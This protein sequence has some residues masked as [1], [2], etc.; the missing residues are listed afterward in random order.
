MRVLIDSAK[1]KDIQK[2]G[3]EA[4]EDVIATK[5]VNTKRFIIFASFSIFWQL[6]KYIR[7][8]QKVGVGGAV[9]DTDDSVV[10]G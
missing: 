1:V 7:Q 6:T 2:V 5:Y 8:W 9:A 4:Y 3:E 10:E